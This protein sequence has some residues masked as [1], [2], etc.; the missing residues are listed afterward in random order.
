MKIML[1]ED[2]VIVV[3]NAMAKSR[4]LDIDFETATYGPDTVQAQIY[5]EALRIVAAL[6]NS[7]PTRE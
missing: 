3:A 5:D 1:G 7:Q 2:D 6:R 4:H